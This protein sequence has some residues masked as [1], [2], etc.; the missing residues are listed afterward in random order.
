MRS[1]KYLAGAAVLLAAFI[2]L[3]VYGQAAND[4][5]AGVTAAQ[6]LQMLH[7]GNARFAAGKSLHPRLDAARM[8]ETAAHGQRPIAAILGCSD[9]R[10][11]VE[12]IFDQGI[13]DLFVVRVAGN[14]AAA[15][16]LGSLEYAV[17]HL[18]APLIVVLGHTAC[19]AVT[20]AATDAQEPPNV[21]QL[22]GRIKPAVRQAAAQHPLASGSELIPLAIESNVRQAIAD[23]LTGSPILRQSVDG[24]KITI[25]GAIYDI[26]DGHV[27]WLGNQP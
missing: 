6:A 23:I 20:A 25:V 16:Q 2:G 21:A 15:D 24:G 3:A 5:G 22:L 12:A 10:A 17:G 8:A 14:V 1:G 27:K 18:G 19:G 13:G 11:P 7:D 9:S 4:M 26:A